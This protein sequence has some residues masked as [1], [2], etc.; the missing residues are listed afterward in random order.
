MLQEL[1][2]GLEATVANAGS[3]QETGAKA[4]AVNIHLRRLVDALHAALPADHDAVPATFDPAGV[5]V[6]LDRLD[7]LLATADFD[8]G[9][10]F[11]ASSSLLRAALGD[12]VSEFEAPMRNHDYP[13]A[14][15]ALRA[16]RARRATKLPHEGP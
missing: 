14:L 10:T 4:A 11:R 9:A 2:A 5:D 6:I 7:N 1:A 3:A 15:E 13:A 12:A 16:V 8:V